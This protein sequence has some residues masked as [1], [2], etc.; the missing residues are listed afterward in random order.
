MSGTFMVVAP[1]PP[2]FLH[3]EG[4]LFSSL[5]RTE[6]TPNI[7]HWSITEAPKG[8][9]CPTMRVNGSFSLKGA[10]SSSQVE[11]GSSPDNLPFPRHISSLL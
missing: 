5:P 10:V 7:S 11:E 2:D 4:D 1:T 8:G 3:Q 6:D 9:G